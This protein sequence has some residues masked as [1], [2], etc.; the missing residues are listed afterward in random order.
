MTLGTWPSNSWEIQGRNAKL[1]VIDFRFVPGVTGKE[2]SSVEKPFFE[3]FMK[4]ISSKGQ[5][6]LTDLPSWLFICGDVTALE[7]VEEFAK[8][9]PLVEVFDMF[10]FEYVHVPNERLGGFSAKSKLAT[11]NVRLLFL[12]K[13]ELSTIPRTRK[14]YKAPEHV[15]YEKARMYKELEYAMY[16]LE[17]RMEFFLKVLHLFCK[18]G[19]S[20]AQVY[21]GTKLLAASVVSLFLFSSTRG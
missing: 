16:P 8:K 7:Q 17:L 3:E 15:V 5:P 1:G 14:L 10:P 19:E 12:I 18:P 6:V 9:P 20:V 21:C 4:L 13:K 2:R 11:E